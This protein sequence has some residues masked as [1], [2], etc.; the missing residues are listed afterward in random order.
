MGLRSPDLTL[1]LF[2]SSKITFYVGCNYNFS[3]HIQISKL[4][5][6]D[7]NHLGFG[8]YFPDHMLEADYEDGEWKNV[9]IRPYQ[10]LQFCLHYT[11]CIMLKQFWRLKAHK[12]EGNVFI[13]FNYEILKAFQTVLKERLAM[14]QVPEELFIGGMK[15]LVNVDKDFIPSGVWWIIVH[16]PFMF[17]YRRNLRRKGGKNI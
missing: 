3:E 14:P 7:F 17:D 11:F 2:N 8:K 12:D 9:R 1:W 6:V 5:Q 15:Q 13:F 16:E 4:S 10:T